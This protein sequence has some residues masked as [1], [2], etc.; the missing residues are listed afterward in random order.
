MKMF[1]HYNPINLKIIGDKVT[2]QSK[3]YGFIEFFFFY[4]LLI[5]LIF[6][7]NIFFFS[8]NTI[9]DAE[10]AKNTINGQIILG[11]EIRIDFAIPRF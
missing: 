5:L 10:R 1:S 7:F 3:G 2:G 4:F 8:F 6:N 9:D 11:K